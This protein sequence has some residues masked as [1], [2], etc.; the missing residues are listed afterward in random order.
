MCLDRHATKKCLSQSC[1][2]EVEHAR[3][4]ALHGT[5]GQACKVVVNPLRQ[6]AT[7]ARCLARHAT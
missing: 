2:M 7:H 4:S 1:D 6:R 5:Y 3:C